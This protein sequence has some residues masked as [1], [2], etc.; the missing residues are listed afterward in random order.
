MKTLRGSPWRST[1]LAAAAVLA[2]AL[3]ASADLSV[4]VDSRDLPVGGAATMQVLLQ[5]AGEA[6]CG[7][8][9]TLTYDSAVLQVSR[10]E[11]NYQSVGG[12]RRAIQLLHEEP[13]RI[14]F[15]CATPGAA[16]YTPAAPETLA[17]IRIER[18][19]AGPASVK[20]QDAFYTLAANTNFVAASLS[21]IVFTVVGED[22][23]GDGIADVWEM[24]TFGDLTTAGAGTDF[25]KDGVSDLDEF[26]QGSYARIPHLTEPPE[27]EARAATDKSRLTIT[28]FAEPNVRYRVV[29]TDSLTTPDWQPVIFADTPQAEPTKDILVGTGADTSI[30]IPVDDTQ[31]VYYRIVVKEN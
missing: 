28:F 2:G 25:D 21:D 17:V 8:G 13:G 14:V 18:T 22:S 9:V 7:A 4:S 5:P 12:P 27:I 3:V 26:K 1:R 6:I 23:D 10:T 16:P 24:R 11:V 19:A 30:E 15:G 20:V 31:S 29:Q